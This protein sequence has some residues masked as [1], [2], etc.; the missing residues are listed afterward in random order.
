MAFGGKNE[1]VLD[2]AL[3]TK[4]GRA[5][6]DLIAQLQELNAVQTAHKT[7]TVSYGKSGPEQFERYSAQGR[8]N[9]VEFD[10][11]KER[12]LTL[13]KSIDGYSDKVSGAGNVTYRVLHKNNSMLQEGATRYDA[14]GVGAEQMLAFS[15]SMVWAS[16]SMLGVFFSML[17]LTSLMRQGFTSLLGP[18]MDMESTIGKIALGEAFAEKAGLDPA[19]FGDTVEMKERAQDLADMWMMVQGWQG[20]ITTGMVDLSRGIFLDPSSADGLSETSHIIAGAITGIMESL[21]D[22]EMVR[23]TS[24]MLAEVA[25]TADSIAEDLPTI[26]SVFSALTTFKIPFTDISALE[27]F[28]KLGL[29]AAPAMAIFSVLNMMTYQVASI[30]K[31]LSWVGQKSGSIIDNL[32]RITLPGMKPPEIPPIDSKVKVNIDTDEYRKVMNSI[33]GDDIYPKTGVKGPLVTGNIDQLSLRDAYNIIEKFDASG[34][35]MTGKFATTIDDFGNHLNTAGEIIEQFDKAGNKIVYGPDFT[36]SDHALRVLEEIRDAVQVEPLEKLSIDSVAKDVNDLKARLVDMQYDVYEKIDDT[37]VSKYTMVDDAKTGQKKLVIVET[38]DFIDKMDVGGVRVVKKGDPITSEYDELDV[39]RAYKNIDELFDRFNARVG[40]TLDGL[41]LPTKYRYEYGQILS[42]MPETDVESNANVLKIGRYHKQ[43]LESMALRDTSNLINKPMRTMETNPHFVDLGMDFLNQGDVIHDLDNLDIHRLLGHLRELEDLNIQNVYSDYFDFVGEVPAKGALKVYNPNSGVSFTYDDGLDQMIQAIRNPSNTAESI[44]QS[45]VGGRNVVHIMNPETGDVYKKFGPGELLKTVHEMQ[46]PP[47]RPYGKEFYDVANL[48]ETALNE[49]G[50]R[51]LMYE[52]IYGSADEAANI[53]TN[54]LLEEIA[55]ALDINLAKMN[56]N[57]AASG[58]QRTPSQQELVIM[59]DDSSREIATKWGLDPDKVATQIM[60]EYTPQEVYSF[61]KDARVITKEYMTTPGK[62]QVDNALVE[63]AD[64]I[65]KARQAV[66]DEVVRTAMGMPDLTKST[67]IS[68]ETAE[69]ITESYR[70]ILN[71]LDVRDDM[72]VDFKIDTAKSVPGKIAVDGDA[73]TIQSKGIDFDLLNEAI[74]K[75]YNINQDLLSS[76][77][78]DFYHGGASR[79]NAQSMAMG[80]TNTNAITSTPVWKSYT[81]IPL[82]DTRV[83]VRRMLHDADD[84]LP[85]SKPLDIDGMLR[86]VTMQGDDSSKLFARRIGDVGEFA[87][88]GGWMEIDKGIANLDELANTHEILSETDLIARHSSISSAEVVPDVDV[89]TVTSKKKGI[90][91]FLNFRNKENK[92]LVD[93]IEAVDDAL[94]DVKTTPQLDGL[95]D[96]TRGSAMS[97]PRFT[98]SSTDL[99]LKAAGNLDSISMAGMQFAAMGLK[100]QTATDL[101]SGI[102]IVGGIVESISYGK[103]AREKARM[104]ELFWNLMQEDPSRDRQSAIKEAQSMYKKESGELLTV[105]PD[106]SITDWTPEAKEEYESYTGRSIFE[107]PIDQGPME[108]TGVPAW[109]VATMLA[110][111]VITT[112]MSALDNRK[113]YREG[114]EGY[115]PTI[116]QEYLDI[117]P[118]AGLSVEAWQSKD[119]S[120]AELYRQMVLEDDKADEFRQLMGERLAHEE[121]FGGR[122]QQL[123]VLDALDSYK[124]WKKEQTG[125]L[126][127]AVS[128]ELGGIGDTLLMA[129]VG[130]ERWKNIRGA[131]VTDSK[132]AISDDVLFDKFVGEV[133]D[134]VGRGDQVTANLSM[135]N[136]VDV[137][138]D[139]TTNMTFNMTFNVEGDM[140]ETAADKIRDNMTD[141]AKMFSRSSTV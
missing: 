124:D 104:N 86:S 56:D 120:V 137:T 63:R 90:L 73:F 4:N 29:I 88:V 50:M 113:F 53:R 125:G 116:P 118:A 69:E 94:P 76:L 22:P 14:I 138:N 61:K 21:R 72:V 141:F 8:M 42:G 112:G 74:A 96:D 117:S 139:N 39:S 31:L 84:L 103:E 9:R 1:V 110:T 64:R 2:I 30:V 23:A 45:A 136:P 18:I 119:Q 85:Q 19:I 107:T 99:K 70:T 47:A 26:V 87:G 25:K 15:R 32:K 131:S 135:S 49:L 97:G 36:A 80:L 77:Y 83:D 140:K 38:T 127:G 98:M 57:I 114:Y 111:G 68:K 3:R 6:R 91:D 51:R 37:T 71:V 67:Y 16:M 106:K 133:I 82:D 122:D 35:S 81:T 52:A 46:I 126:A 11:N 13:M 58:I 132:M 48:K 130:N 93:S 7:D 79:V 34:N 20:A 75:K 121:M 108:L 62:E 95:L 54:E 33:L 5:V 17:S 41:G 66:P 27:V 92:V 115:M 10:Q 109:D 28:I 12:I 43:K 24:E 128:R 100:S 101:T 134:K 78:L 65:F 89:S 40:T 60:N 55:D 44:R 123:Q 102:P 59:L 129:V 105:L